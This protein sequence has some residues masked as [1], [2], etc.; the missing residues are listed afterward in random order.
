MKWWSRQQNIGAPVRQ[1]FSS[2]SGYAGCIGRVDL[3]L[4]AVFLLAFT[5]LSGTLGPAYADFGTDKCATL[6]PGEHWAG[7]DY[8]DHCGTWCC[9][10]GSPCYAEW[11]YWSITKS[12]SGWGCSYYSDCGSHSCYDCQGVGCC[13]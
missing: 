11:R 4:I 2:R 10:G 3:G 12:Y 7:C 9:Q 13:G 5:A 1:F 6:Q 8:N